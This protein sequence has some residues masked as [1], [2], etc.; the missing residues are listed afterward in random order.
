MPCAAAA[1]DSLSA[2]APAVATAN[3]T[4]ATSAIRRPPT[5]LL[6]SGPPAGAHHEPAS[7]GGQGGPFSE[8]ECDTGVVQHRTDVGEEARSQLSV[9]DAVVEGQRELRDLTRHDPALVHP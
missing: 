2:I 8:R 4:S 7:G 5:A 3:A 9:D 6:L 1:R